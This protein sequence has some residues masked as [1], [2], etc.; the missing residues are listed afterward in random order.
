MARR[1]CPVPNRLAAAAGAAILL[2]VGAPPAVASAPAA[3]VFVPG[4]GVG[5]ATIE[6]ISLRSSG[7]SLSI[8][9]GSAKARYAGAQ[10]NAEAAGVDLGLLEVAGKSPVA[11]GTAMDSFLPP[12]ALPKRV[13]VSSG[14]GASSVRSASFGEGTPLQIGSQYGSARPNSAADAGV[15]GVSLDMPGLASG[16]GGTASSAA[17]LTPGSQRLARADSGMGSLDI[18]GGLVRLEGM[19]WSAVHR[20]GATSAS[21][22]TFT[23]GGMTIGG[24]PF[25]TP[26][27]SSAREGFARAN[28]ALAPLGLALSVPEVV[29]WTRNVAVTPL[30]LTVTPTPELR[31]LVVAALEG[32]QPVRTGLLEA[33]APA[34]MGEDCGMTDAVGFGYLIADL[35]LVVLGDKGGIDLDFGGATA[36]THFATYMNPLNSGYGALDP[37]GVLGPAVPRVR[38]GSPPGA[39]APPGRVLPARAAAAGAAAPSVPGPAAAGQSP[40]ASAQTAPTALGDAAP[41]S[42]I[43]RSTHTAGDGCA[44]R[45]GV[46]AGWL[47]LALIVVLAAADRLR[48]RSSR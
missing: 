7:A 12:G 3:E 1:S 5:S 45:A 14:D 2:A 16:V 11:C 21:T 35:A 31:S 44:R 37:G 17:E 33:L 6:R 43:C 38:G 27:D 32:A 48:A 10:G 41:A 29:K 47:A 19:R 30:R 23:V 34:T 39:V 13:K 28:Q 36:G 40:S 20:T 24:V 42:W 26:D 22:G 46:L 15:G 25:P 9:I 18:A 4:T 8:G